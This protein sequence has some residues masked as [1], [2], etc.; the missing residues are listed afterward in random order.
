M[1]RDCGPSMPDGLPSWRDPDEI[2][3]ESPG[4]K[5][6]REAEGELYQAQNDA[7][8]AELDRFIRNKD[9]IMAALGELLIYAR[10]P[11]CGLGSKTPWPVHVVQNADKAI[12]EVEGR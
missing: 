8:R 10:A 2:G 1:K 9:A 12:A 5:A 4:E 3:P 6:Q 11:A 7:Q